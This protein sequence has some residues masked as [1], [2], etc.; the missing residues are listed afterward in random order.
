MSDRSMELLG[1]LRSVSA[2]A[3]H[4][5]NRIAQELAQGL[6]RAD[7]ERRALERQIAA[8][9]LRLDDAQRVAAA[10]GEERDRLQIAAQS[11]ADE[12]DTRACAAINAIAAAVWPILDSVASYND[13]SNRADL[14]ASIIIQADILIDL[15]PARS[16]GVPA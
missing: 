8:L 11:N 14:I 5:I 1:E 10:V 13:S 6:E 16:Q 15:L 12:A 2:R 4:E 3:T 7:S 9:A